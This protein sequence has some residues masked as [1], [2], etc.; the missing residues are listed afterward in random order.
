M[1]H[2]ARR[3]PDK[4]PGGSGVTGSPKK[5][6]KE[7]KDDLAPLFDITL[8]LHPT[9]QRALLKEKKSTHLQLQESWDPF[10]I[11]KRFHHGTTE[12]L[13]GDF[14]KEAC[15]LFDEGKA[16]EKSKKRKKS[17][18]SEEAANEMDEN[19]T[20]GSGD[21]NSPEKQDEDTETGSVQDETYMTP[22]DVKEIIC[23]NLRQQQFTKR[24][25]TAKLMEACNGIAS[26]M[27]EMLTGE[28]PEDEVIGIDDV[29]QS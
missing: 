8:K 2:E 27:I 20:A 29:L 9:F 13:V 3:S 4:K 23:N 18:P 11:A 1:V 28:A 21:A 14:F 10:E 7:Q 15:E 12:I 16:K 22:E 19:N 17:V 24:S 25:L 6:V 26:D 5:L